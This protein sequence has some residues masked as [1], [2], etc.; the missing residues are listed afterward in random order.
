MSI[1]ASM[2]EP[3]PRLDMETIFVI[4]LNYGMEDI[5]NVS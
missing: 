5:V 3:V 2:V 4:V 1:L